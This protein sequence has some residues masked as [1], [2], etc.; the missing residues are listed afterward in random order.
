MYINDARIKRISQN[1]NSNS[2]KHLIALFLIMAS[3]NSVGQTL[4]YI[5]SSLPIEMRVND[6]LQKMTLD[7]QA[8]QLIGEYSVDSL[9]FDENGNFISTQDT[10]VL[11]HG[12][13]SYGVWFLRG[14]QSLRCQAQCI[15][16]IQRY[17][18]EKTRLGIPVF[19]FGESLHGFMANGATSFPQAIAL[20][21]TD[22]TFKKRE[23][24]CRS[25]RKNTP[26]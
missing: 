21:Y 6:L 19:T 13:G 18:I 16:G 26:L 3:V 23:T 9:A 4:H 12:I 11:N 5:N 25:G 22:D 17:M 15:N 1:D 24:A 14:E 8:A 7:E 2:M 10:A 20:G